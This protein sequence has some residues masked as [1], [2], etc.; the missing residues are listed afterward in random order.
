MSEE[1]TLL[2]GRELV[3][4]V[5]KVI[6]EKK[7][8]NVSLLNLQGLSDVADFFL[9]TTCSSD[10]QMRAIVNAISRA[11]KSEKIKPLG[12]EYK[13]GNRW[14]VIDLGEIIIHLFEEEHRDYFDLERLWA[15]AE[16][17]VLVADDYLDDDMSEDD[18]EYG[19]I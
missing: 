6:F 14:T 5:A 12:I 7:A 1:K 4:F 18:D 9:I 2:S 17:E 15:D 13:S 19:Y 16:K 3:D 11:L 10:A 8:D